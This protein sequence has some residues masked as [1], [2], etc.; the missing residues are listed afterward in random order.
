MSLTGPIVILGFMGCGK[1]EV[2]RAL[3]RRL[4]LPLIDLDVTIAQQQGRT[5]A[6]LIREDGEQ[7]FRA[8]ETKTLHAIL[9]SD[10]RAVIAL[11]GGAW[12]TELNRRLIDEYDCLSVWLDAPFDLCWQRI[13]TSAEDRP[14]SRTRERAE[15]L[16]RERQPIYQQAMVRV[17]VEAQESVETV[18]ARVENYLAQR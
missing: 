13:E 17:A 10:R 12:I 11:G 7:S 15:Q 8:I 1:T 2:A 18:V 5:A 3:A 6:Q 14:L 9:E 4:D 16:Y